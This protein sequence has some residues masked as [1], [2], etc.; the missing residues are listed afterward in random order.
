MNSDVI[1]GIVIGVLSCIVVILA[2]N[3]YWELYSDVCDLRTERKELQ[4]KIRNLRTDIVRT[5]ED[6]NDYYEWR[7]EK[8]ERRAK[9]N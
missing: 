4:E 1:G 9:C 3:W 6:V 2:K 7:K 8:D 5:Q